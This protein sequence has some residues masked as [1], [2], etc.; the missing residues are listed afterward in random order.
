V[1]PVAPLAAALLAAT[2][3]SARP[4][5]AALLTRLAL[6]RLVLR[7][8]LV[9]VLVF[10]RALFRLRAATL[11]LRIAGVLI[12]MLLIH[13]YSNERVGPS[14]RNASGRPDFDL[15]PVRT[16]PYAQP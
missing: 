10:L 13:I 2:L 16:L 5:T 9:P 3:L 8:R 11:L 7:A 4:L 12:R 1:L 15:T 14:V 6:A